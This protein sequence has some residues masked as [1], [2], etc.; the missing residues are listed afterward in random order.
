MG[1]LECASKPLGRPAGG[2]GHREAKT[3]GKRQ[4]GHRPTHGI[5]RVRIIPWSMRSDDEGRRNGHLTCATDGGNRVS[6]DPP[7]GL[8][9]CRRSCAAT[10]RR[11]SLFLRRGA[12]VLFAAQKSGVEGI[13]SSPY[14][15]PLVE[16]HVE[17]GTGLHRKMTIHHLCNLCWSNYIKFQRFA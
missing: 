15:F 2:N 3:I 13:A 9:L 6:D 11:H 8:F 7:A 10:L 14:V 4:K 16:Y 1:G 12:L 17:S 5:E